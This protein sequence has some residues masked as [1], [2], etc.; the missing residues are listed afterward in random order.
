MEDSGVGSGQ[1]AAMDLDAR[2]QSK[3]D[4]AP[5]F[6]LLPQLRA[7]ALEVVNTMAGVDGAGLPGLGTSRLRKTTQLSGGPPS[8][9]TIEDDSKS[10]EE[11]SAA[12][13]TTT[14]AGARPWLAT[15]PQL[16]PRSAPGV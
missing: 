7:C 8:K 1:R 3:A 13:H 14:Q 12:A 16:E 4:H 10:T 6:G 9:G 15:D 11:G 5:I 2:G